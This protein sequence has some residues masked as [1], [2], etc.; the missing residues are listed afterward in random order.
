MGQDPHIAFGERWNKFHNII[1][2]G[3][4]TGKSF[5][6]KR[7]MI[8]MVRYGYLEETYYDYNFIP[9]VGDDGHVVGHYC[10]AGDAIREAILERRKHLTQGLSSELS[11]CKDMGEFWP[12]FRKGL[13][14]GDK[15][16]P[17]VAL[18]AVSQ[19][20]SEPSCPQ[21]GRT[22]CLLEECVGVDAD[23]L[24]SRLVFPRGLHPP[25]S[26]LTN[27][28]KLLARLFQSSL[29][30]PNPLLLTR[31]MLPS[32]FLAGITWRGF[33]VPSEEF[34]IVPLR[35]NQGAVVGFM[36]AGLN[37]MKRYRQDNDYEDLI[38][39]V[40]QQIATP[41]ASSLLQSEEIKKG[42]ERLI[43]RSE[44]LKRSEA[45]YRNFAEQAPIGVALVA[46]N[47]CIEFAN[48]A[49]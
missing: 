36:F 10:Q 24:P 46:P 26:I 16:F 17:F 48:E 8:P 31:N 12:A 49:W 1:K 6:E 41:R 23:Q 7:Q 33:G 45:K 44:E 42:E 21:A 22:T 4:E 5:V 9:I 11:D 38:K 27:F 18:Y 19:F 14:L 25:F 32:L 2:S 13:S 47:R 37:P 43:L 29:E 40:T 34:L 28:D 20:G 3:E 15:D 35:T 39:M 30:D